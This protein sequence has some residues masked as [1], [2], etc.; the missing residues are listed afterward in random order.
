MKY[1][2]E[3]HND[4]LEQKCRQL[5]AELRD[6]IRMAKETENETSYKLKMKIKRLETEYIP[7]AKHEEIVNL[8]LEKYETKYQEQLSSIYSQAVKQVELRVKEEI[9]NTNREKHKV[10]MYVKE[11]E[12]LNEQLRSQLSRKPN[13]LL[14]SVKLSS[15]SFVS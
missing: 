11:L 2:E 8:E 7:L 14:N 1:I 3:Q 4:F 15:A 9:A 13:K 5:D 12:A 10:E 6:E